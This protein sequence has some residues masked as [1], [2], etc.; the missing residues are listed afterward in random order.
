MFSHRLAT[1]GD[2]YLLSGASNGRALIWNSNLSFPSEPDSPYSTQVT[3]ENRLPV[4]QLDF[5]EKE[6][7]SVVCT[8]DSTSS[9]YNSSDTQHIYKGNF[10]PNYK[11]DVHRL[12]DEGNGMVPV[13]RPYRVER[14]EERIVSVCRPGWS[15]AGSE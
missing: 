15:R 14:N 6:D 3:I 4:Y 5:Y 9:I 2:R 1:F 11:L 12:Y 7:I 10:R 13:S 8:D